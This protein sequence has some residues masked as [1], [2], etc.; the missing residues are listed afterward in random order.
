MRPAATV[1]SVVYVSDMTD[2]VVDV[3]P[4]KTPNQP[5]VA[6]L[7]GLNGPVGIAV[8]PNRDVY[9]ATYNTPGVAVF[10]KNQTTPYATIPMPNT[11]AGGNDIAIGDGSVYVVNF[12]DTIVVVPLGSTTPSETLTDPNMAD[13]YGVAVDPSGD[14]FD[15]GYNNTM[16]IVDEFVAGSQNP[17]ALPIS[18][19]CCYTDGLALDASNNLYV[20]ESGDQEIAEYAPPYTGSPVNQIHFSGG[21][22]YG[23]ALTRP[24]KAIWIACGGLAEGVK[25]GVHGR[26]MSNTSTVP[27]AIGIA[28]RPPSGT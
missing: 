8:A 28:I 5:P 26:L 27:N 23:L 4:A 16:P 12:P 1:G 9:V 3:F 6:Q 19:T 24:D 20:D 7:T 15:I 18:L 2:N 13:I 25:Y 17:T 22:C 10:H 11:S 21:S 14:V